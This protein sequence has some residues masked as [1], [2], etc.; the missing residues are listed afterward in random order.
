[1]VA[2]AAPIL[3]RRVEWTFLRFVRGLYWPE[4]PDALNAPA[5]KPLDPISGLAGAGVD[6]PLLQA[7]APV[8]SRGTAG[9]LRP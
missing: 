4:G 3:T 6:R 1:M 9:G 7:L 2:A 8:L 5:S